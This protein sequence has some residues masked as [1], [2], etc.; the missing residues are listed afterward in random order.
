MQ[1]LIAIKSIHLTVEIYIGYKTSPKK[2]KWVFLMEAYFQKV[3]LISQIDQSSGQA[4]KIF[5]FLSNKCDYEVS[6]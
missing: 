2:E 6:F 4:Y 5:A 3:Y 1:V